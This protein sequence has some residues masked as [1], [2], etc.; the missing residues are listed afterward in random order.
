MRKWGFLL[1]IEPYAA[2]WI[3]CSWNF[4]F[5]WHIR[6]IEGAPLWRP[7]T[8]S[9]I[10]SAISPTLSDQRLDLFWSIK[11]LWISREMSGSMEPFSAREWGQIDREDESV[12]EKIKS[13]G[14]VENKVCMSNILS[15]DSTSYTQCDYGE[16]TKSYTNVILVVCHL[17][18]PRSY[19]ENDGLVID[20]TIWIK[21]VLV[22]TV[23]T[24]P[25]HIIWIGILTVS[26]SSLKNSKSV[27]CVT[28]SCTFWDDG[29]MMWHFFW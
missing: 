7:N 24:I 18:F 11:R 4:S 2:T 15:V 23:A 1:Q 26:I 27:C 17:I 22:P 19:C 6:A 12:M 20:C 13:V 5:K 3:P 8:C 9:M 16:N 21:R 14:I 25:S 10:T 28:P 29:R